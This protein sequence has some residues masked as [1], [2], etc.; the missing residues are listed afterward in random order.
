M[1]L[2]A[3]VSGIITTSS[4]IQYLRTGVIDNTHQDFVEPQDQKGFQTALSS[5]NIFA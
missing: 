2:P 3:L 4:T 5:I 1:I